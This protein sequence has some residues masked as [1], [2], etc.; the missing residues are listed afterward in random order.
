[1][2]SS[3]KNTNK[4]LHQSKLFVFLGIFWIVIWIILFL[5]TNVLNATISFLVSA[6]Y[7]QTCTGYS[8]L[9]MA[10]LL[11][12]FLIGGL[13]ISYGAISRD[14]EKQATRLISFAFA[15]SLASLAVYY[16]ANLF[17]NGL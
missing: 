14:R 10:I 17:I 4:L 7:C 12:S 5:N 13:G 1:M 3:S 11:L 8:L 15:V 6:G 2:R 16:W 9:T